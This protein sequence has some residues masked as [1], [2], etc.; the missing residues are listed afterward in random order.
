MHTKYIMI[1]LD[2]S[3]LNTSTSEIFSN[4]MISVVYVKFENNL[5]DPLTKALSVEWEQCPC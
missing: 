4:G 2:I 3:A 1:V 5:I